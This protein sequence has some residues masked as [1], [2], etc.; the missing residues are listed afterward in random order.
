[1]KLGKLIQNDNPEIMFPIENVKS[2]VHILGTVTN[3]LKFVVQYH[4]AS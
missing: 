2:N 4:I 3:N 1:M